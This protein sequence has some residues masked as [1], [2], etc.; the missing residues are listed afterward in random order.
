MPTV[1]TYTRDTQLIPVSSADLKT[2]HRQALA[3]LAN[4]VR[5]DRFVVSRRVSPNARAIDAPKPISTRQA[6]TP[7]TVD[8]ATSELAQVVTVRRTWQTEVAEATDDAVQQIL[9]AAQSDG[10]QGS[11][12]RITDIRMGDVVEHRAG[13]GP[14]EAS[15]MVCDERAICMGCSSRLYG[16]ESSGACPSCGRLLVDTGAE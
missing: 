13:D 2:R 12:V 16:E 15:L 7:Y 5:G 8:V 9:D 4:D 14:G 11:L 3:G 6:R 1:L 10:P